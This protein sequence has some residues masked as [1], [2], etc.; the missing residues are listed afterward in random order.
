MTFTG[1]FFTRFDAADKDIVSMTKTGLKLAAGEVGSISV[2]KTPVDT[3]NLRR[4]EYETDVQKEGS[5]FVVEVGYEADYA[6]PVHEITTNRH[7][8]G[9]AK[10]LE[11]ALKEFSNKM[12]GKIKESIKL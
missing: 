10:F 3:A 2:R 9:E 11:K 7:R 8:V 6:V 1:D 5:G 4:S 12:P